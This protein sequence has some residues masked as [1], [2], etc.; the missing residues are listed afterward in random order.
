MIER[1][2]AR[3]RAHPVRYPLAALGTHERTPEEARR[4]VLEAAARIMAE[5]G[6][7]G[8]TIGAEEDAEAAIYVVAYLVPAPA[9]RAPGLV[10]AAAV[11]LRAL[12]EIRSDDGITNDAA[13]A[14]YGMARGTCPHP[15]S[16]IIGAIRVCS[17]CGISG[18][19]R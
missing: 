10:V 11:L 16:A 1:Q 19:T 9:V 5:L 15:T 13:V 17:A 7:D 12:E 14:L 6:D 3:L 18:V 8:I 2:L 4:L